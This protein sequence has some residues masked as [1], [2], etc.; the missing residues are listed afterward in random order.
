MAGTFESSHAVNIQNVLLPEFSRS[1]RL[2]SF[3]ARIIDANLK[4]DLIIGRRELTNFS[5][6]LSFS[7]HTVK[8]ADVS[9]PMSDLASLNTVLSTTVSL[10]T[11]LYLDL[12]LEDEDNDDACASD[13]RPNDYHEVQVKDVAESCEHL[14]PEKR[15][16]LFQVL[17]K[18]KKLFSGKLGHY[19]H[20]KIHL[21][22]QEGAV[23]KHQR[24]YPVPKANMEVFKNE[25]DNLVRHGVLER[26]GR[27]EWAAP[28]FVVPKK[29]GKVRWVSDFRALNKFIKRR[30][31]PIPRINDILSRRSGYKFFSKI[32]I[33]MQYYTFELDDESSDL[34]TIA[35]PFGLYKY[36]RLPMGICQSPDVA[37]DIMEKVLKDIAEIETYIDDI[38]CFNDD[39]KSHLTTL[40]VV[41]ERLQANGFTVNPAKCEWGVQETDWLGYWLTPTGLKPWQ[42]KVQAILDMRAPENLTQLR[43]FIGSVNW[44]RDMWPRRAHTLAPLTKL[45]GTKVFVWKDD[46]QKA[47]EAMKAIMSSEALLRYPDHNLPFDIETDASDY[48]LGAVIKQGGH[49]VAYYTRRL[50]SAQANYTTIE[51][52]LLSVVETLK[53]FRSMLLGARINVFTDHKNLTHALTSFSTQRVLRW[54]IS[55]EE[56][57]PTFNYIPGPDNVVADALSRV[58]T[59]STTPLVEEKSPSNSRLTYSDPNNMTA[60]TM[61]HATVNSSFHSLL[62]EPQLMDCFLLHPTFDDENRYPLDYRT[63][64]DYQLLDQHLLAAVATQPKWIM[65]QMSPNLEL[66]CHSAS[67]GVAADDWKI[68]IPDGMLDK[69]INWYHLSLTHV[70]MTRLKETMG[71]HFYHAKLDERIRQIVGKCDP[72]Q[73]YKSG[74]RAYAELPPRHA[75]L[76]PW[77]EIHIDLI[78]P[79]SFSVNGVALHFSALTIIDPVTNLVE[80]VRIASKSAQH[81][82]MQLENAWL[83]RYPRPMRCVHDQGGEFIGRAFS[84]I[85]QDDNGVKLVPT[86]VKNPQANAICER[87][88]QTIGNTLRTMLLVNPPNDI[89]DA[90]DLI[91]SVLATAMHATRAS[92]H[93]SLMNRTPGALAFHRDMML[94]IPLVADLITIQN[95]R[96]AI[97]DETLRKA[98]LHRLNHDYA[99]G[100]FVLFKVF[101]P[102]KLEA[103]WHGP[104]E[105][106]RVHVNGTLTIRL[107]AHTIE[108]VNVRRLKPYRS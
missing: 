25:L 3:Q 49:P 53:K 7:D 52:E 92:A 54:R 23:P 45:T 71:T 93:R 37:Q 50:N 73:K 95:S 27:S 11:E 8:F 108:R 48:Q 78:G 90:N 74:G 88:H 43:S 36:K 19:P 101:A 83:S 34:C 107:T 30:I 66:V 26:T 1:R 2:E 38:G 104:Y 9:R 32:D 91:D 87:V 16:D 31:Y 65:K 33:S 105:I 55:I 70:G 40:Q 106:L 98:N 6:D 94:D 96:Q 47:F 56:F 18:F 79:W 80:I 62:D 84:R 103:R 51:K 63:L 82:G 68:A 57:N 35:T 86:T 67:S 69:L 44:Y 29:D 64:R 12:L 75:I 22:L 42:K 99:A 97:I 20:E 14:S 81:V 100:E 77:H 89:L 5:I 15:E 13:I 39:W 24:A 76:A 10:A 60:E 28:T 85:I 58:P 59:K 21:D 46:Q 17:S 4:Y 72:C 102:A 61:F 41:L